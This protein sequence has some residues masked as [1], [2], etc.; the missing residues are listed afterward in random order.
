MNYQEYDGKTK[1]DIKSK[2]NLEENE[3]L[4]KYSE[5]KGGL[6]KSN[7]LKAYVYKIEDVCQ[8]IKKY[9]QELLQ[10]MNIENPTFESKIRDGQ[11]N[12][13]IYSGNNAILIGK[14]GQNL[15]AIQ[16]VVRQYIYSKIG[17]YPYILLDVEDYKDKQKGYLERLAKNLALEVRKT[18]KEV[19]MENMNSYERRIVHNVLSDFKGITSS[20]E[21]DEPN[22]HI[23][24]KPLDE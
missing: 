24:I 8:E 6:F 18:K 10:N 23:V 2:I 1:E 22:R 16:N 14:N 11:I 12:I 21:G 4:V 13:K 20:S 19:K 7:S 9:L 3:Y 15:A 5:Q 17:L